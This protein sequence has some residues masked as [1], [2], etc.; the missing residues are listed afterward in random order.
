MLAGMVAASIIFMTTSLDVL[1]AAG[2][3]AFLRNGM[4]EK[5][6][7]SQ[8]DWNYDEVANFLENLV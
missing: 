7:L 4:F 1:E 8:I 2:A 5:L 6:M 3:A